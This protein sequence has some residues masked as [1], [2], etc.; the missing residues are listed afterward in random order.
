MKSM[1]GK[2]T[3]DLKFPLAN[4]ELSFQFFC[5]KLSIKERNWMIFI[6]LTTLYHNQDKFSKN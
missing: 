3:G 6:C 1:N 2:I 5:G 4:K